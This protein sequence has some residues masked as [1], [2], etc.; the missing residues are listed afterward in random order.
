MSPV[1]ADVLHPPARDLGEVTDVHPAARILRRNSG[2][3]TSARCEPRTAAS[4]AAGSNRVGD[5]L[6]RDC[7]LVGTYDSPQDRWSRGLVAWTGRR[8][9]AP[10]PPRVISGRLPGRDLARHRQV[11]ALFHH[12]EAVLAVHWSLS[13]QGRELLS[14]Y[15]FTTR[16]AATMSFSRSANA[17]AARPS[18]AQRTLRRSG[19]PVPQ[20]RGRA[21]GRSW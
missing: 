8:G 12:C 7:S 4:T 9:I 13:I 14:R 11:L 21:C 20:A 17:A 18:G 2:K 10:P 16:A 6:L 1:R 15:V 5:R 19:P 3:M